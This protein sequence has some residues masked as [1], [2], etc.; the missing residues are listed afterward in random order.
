MLKN[1]QTDC[2]EWKGNPKGEFSFK[3]CWDIIRVKYH[4]WPFG[5]ISW[6]PN[7]CPK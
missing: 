2:W 5:S 7:H 4:V 1:A 3:N 6:Y